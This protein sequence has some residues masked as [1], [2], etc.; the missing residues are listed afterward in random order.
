MDN[1]D[2]LSKEEKENIK[3]IIS[4][5]SYDDIKRQASSINKDEVIKK[6]RSMGLDSVADKYASMTDAQLMELLSNNPNILK[7]IE[8]FIK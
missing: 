8:K 2:F 6:M 7:I 4:G 1:R 3:N 5:F